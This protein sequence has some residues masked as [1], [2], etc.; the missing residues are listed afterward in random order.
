MVVL[1]L[2]KEESQQLLEL[3]DIAT[4]TGGLQV[5]QAALPLATK[6]LQASQPAKQ[7]G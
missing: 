1:E 2:T 6:L 5:A 3:L 4:K 7:D